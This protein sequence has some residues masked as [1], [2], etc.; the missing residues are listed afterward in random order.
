M[1]KN[2]LFGVQS[3]RLIATLNAKSVKNTEALY[4]LCPMLI[5]Y[6]NYTHGITIVSSGLIFGR[7]FEFVCRSPIFKLACIR[8]GFT[9]G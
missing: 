3:G 9:Q 5:H 7:I 2:S 4:I 1:P 6:P 8:V